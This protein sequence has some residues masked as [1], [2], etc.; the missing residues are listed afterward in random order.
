MT[1]KN[2]KH[3]KMS[4]I[5]KK[6]NRRKRKKNRSKK[7]KKREMGRVRAYRLNLLLEILHEH[8]L[9]DTDLLV[10]LLL[11]WNIELDLQT[12]INK[13][14]GGEKKGRREGERGRTKVPQ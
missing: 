1:Y 8:V 5:Y 2:S 7:E 10:V 6:R 9:V 12:N 14:G 3:R 13:E 4:G 11:A